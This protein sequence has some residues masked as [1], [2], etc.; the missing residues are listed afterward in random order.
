MQ[1]RRVVASCLVLGLFAVAA[2]SLSAQRNN[3]NKQQPPKRTEAEQK[4]IDALIKLVDAVAAGTQPAPADIPI[5]WEANHFVKGQADTYIP[6]TL[7]V[8]RSKMNAAGAAYYVRV[9]D[10]N[11][12]APAAGAKND[13]NAPVRYPWDGVTFFDIPQGGKISRAMALKAGEYEAFIVVKDKGTNQRN[14]PAPKIGMLRKT[15]TV[16]DYTTAELK[17]S[18]VLLASNVEPVTTPLSAQEQEANP[19]VFGPMK[20]TPSPDGKYA[21][22]GELQV[23]F[24]IYGA[25]EAAAGKPDVTVEF[26]FHQKLPEGEKY[27]NKT[28]PQTLNGQTLPAEFSLAAGHQLP[29]SLI[30]PLASF[31]EGAYRLEIKVTDKASGKSL[32]ENVNFSVS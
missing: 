8:D 26:N 28:Q 18:S 22:S 23:I 3:D 16:P 15:I 29:G 1:I 2:D 9:I 13:K 10:K 19:Y 21:K 6:Y 17:T 25:M 14:A 31:P 7:T 24:W 27:F 12:A 11:A 5:T 30:I 4:D 20:I 32:T